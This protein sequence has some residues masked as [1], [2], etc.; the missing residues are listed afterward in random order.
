MVVRHP[1]KRIVSEWKFR[2][3]GGRKMQNNVTHMNFQL[4]HLLQKVYDSRPVNGSDLAAHPRAYFARFG[5]FVPQSD[6]LVP[7]V[8]VLK[9]ESLSHELSCLMKAYN[10][11]W[12]LLSK[13]KNMSKGK[14][15]VANLTRETKDWID[16][17]YAEDFI[18]FGYKPLQ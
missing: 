17:V 12:K 9:Q 14:V 6:F 3:L 8:H 5:H 18:R 2:P 11:N 10:L 16:K 4:I 1:Y 15:T 13:R 7:N